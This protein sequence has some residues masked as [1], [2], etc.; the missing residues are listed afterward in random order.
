MLKWSAIISD[1]GVYN[2]PLLEVL[3]YTNLFYCKYSIIETYNINCTINLIMMTTLELFPLRK[4]K[5]VIAI[6]KMQLNGQLTT[7][8]KY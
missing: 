1:L 5:N 3:S 4:A 7:I 6:G 8:T 2:L